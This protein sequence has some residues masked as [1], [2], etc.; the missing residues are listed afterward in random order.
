[1]RRLYTYTRTNMIQKP[2]Q[3]HN[4]SSH[5]QKK[6]KEKTDALNLVVVIV[7]KELLLYIGLPFSKTPKS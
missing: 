4:V 1:M 2:S 6:E 3:Q 7:L 5:P